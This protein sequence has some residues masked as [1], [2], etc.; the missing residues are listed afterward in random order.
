MDNGNNG[1]FSWT[2]AVVRK[3]RRCSIMINT[4]NTGVMLLPFSSRFVSRKAL[5]SPITGRLFSF[6]TNIPL[7][8]FVS[9]RLM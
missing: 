1:V 9:R 3:F 2:S 8:Y 6:K 4:A 5:N 7:S